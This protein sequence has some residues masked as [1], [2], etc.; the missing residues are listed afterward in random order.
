VLLGTSWFMD[1]STPD[2]YGFLHPTGT[3]VGG[4]EWRSIGADRDKRCP[5]GTRG[6]VRM[7][8]SWGRK[9]ANFGRAWVTFG[10]LDR[11]IKENGEA[12]TATEIRVAM[13]A[14]VPSQTQIYSQMA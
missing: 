10:D 11:L 13:F 4:H 14:D 8:N 9:W 6:A 12:V 1:M 5:D 3:N 2:R 7:V